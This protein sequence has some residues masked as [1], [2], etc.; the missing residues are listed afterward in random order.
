MLPRLAPVATIL[1]S[2]VDERRGS[3]YPRVETLATRFPAV[4]GV[5]TLGPGFHGKRWEGVS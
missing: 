5:V 1:A 2:A 4:Q 3:V